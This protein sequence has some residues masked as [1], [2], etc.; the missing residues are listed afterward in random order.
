[1]QRFIPADF[2]VALAGRGGDLA[3]PL[4]RQRRGQRRGIIAAASLGMAKIARPPC[5]TSQRP[6]LAIGGPFEQ[7]RAREH[8][9]GGGLGVNR[10]K[11]HEPGH[12]ARCTRAP[13]LRRVERAVR[14]DSGEHARATGSAEGLT[15]TADGILVAT[16]SGRD[17]VDV[18]R[19]GADRAA[20]ESNFALLEG[21][22]P[23]AATVFLLARRAIENNGPIAGR[24]E[25]S[26]NG[27]DIL[28]HHHRIQPS[29]VNGNMVR[30][31]HLQHLVRGGPERLA[32]SQIQ[33]DD[34]LLAS[35]G[36]QAKF[37][38]HLLRVTPIVPLVLAPAPLPFH[39]INRVFVPPLPRND[40]H[41]PVRCPH[42]GRERIILPEGFARLEIVGHHRPFR[43]FVVQPPANHTRQLANMIAVFPVRDHEHI[44]EHQQ[45]RGHER[46]GQHAKPLARLA[47]KLH[48]LLGFVGCVYLAVGGDQ[49][50]PGT[51]VQI[52][53]KNR[54]ELVTPEKRPVPGIARD[55]ILIVNLV[56]GVHLPV[57]P[58]EIFPRTGRHVV[59]APIRDRQA[60]RIGPLVR[61]HHAIADIKGQVLV[62]THAKGPSHDR[63]IRRAT[64]APRVA[65]VVRPLVH[66]RRARLG[67]HLPALAGCEAQ[68]AAGR[69]HAESFRFRKP[70]LFRTSP[71]FDDQRIEQVVAIGQ[72]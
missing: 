38:L 68:H 32:A 6:L 51:V 52:A 39:R 11:R 54:P 69:D 59:H 42:R 50:R 55:E 46:R 7:L 64:I 31:R 2:R 34:I 65:I 44:V 53:V 63:V 12:D 57:G 21:G 58:F 23:A 5:V 35:P 16:I 15:F 70:P 25:A 37:F 61:T 71:L 27:V 3:I 45:N 17:L 20:A 62:P 8:L 29:H 13:G 66:A 41:P 10:P 60:S 14:R 4:H 24:P 47:V 49:G 26:R 19:R 28:A 30:G 33:R 48:Q 1:M 22:K 36:G 43:D 67:N 56:R 40:I 18:N 72:G 9:L